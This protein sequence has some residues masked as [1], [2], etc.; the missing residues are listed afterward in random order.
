VSI[1]INKIETILKLIRTDDDAL[2]ET[3]RLMWTDGKPED[4]KF[5]KDIKAGR[6]N[7]ILPTSASHAL[8]TVA[9]AV[10]KV[11]EVTGAKAVTSSMTNTAKMGVEGLKQFGHATKT[12]FGDFATSMLTGNILGDSKKASSS[13]PA[14]KK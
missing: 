1:H 6:S 2:E 5:I 11:G 7:P 13:Q 4:L 8:N 9:G 14:K 12:A 3:F 10:G